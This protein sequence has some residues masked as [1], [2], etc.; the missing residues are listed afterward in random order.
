MIQTYKTGGNCDAWCTKCRMDLAHTIVAMVNRIPV[1]VMCNTCGGGH[2]F[3]TPKG[4]AASKTKA[5]TTVKAPAKKRTTKAQREEMAAVEALQVEWKTLASRHLGLEAERYR[6]TGEYAP[7]TK[8]DHLKF[9][10][11][12]V[13]KE[14]SFNR[15]SV[16]FEDEEKTLIVRHGQKPAKKA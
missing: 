7:A 11:G 1:Q 12:F 2:K 16:L 15:I 5:G 8:L 13:L 9:G 14:L 6:V 4:A 3:R 10:I